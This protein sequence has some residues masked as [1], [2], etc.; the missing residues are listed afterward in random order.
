M[1]DDLRRAVE[2][3]PMY[4]DGGWH[5]PADAVED[6]RRRVLA[7]LDQRPASPDPALREIVERTARMGLCSQTHHEHLVRAARA[8]LADTEEAGR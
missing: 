1:T 2:A 7:L 8:A 3:L 6:Y 4:P 5:T